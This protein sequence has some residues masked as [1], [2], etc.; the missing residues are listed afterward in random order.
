MR[1]EWSGVSTA[2]STT[3]SP[4]SIFLKKSS[5]HA[6]KSSAATARSTSRAAHQDRLIPWHKGA[7]RVISAAPRPARRQDQRILRLLLISSVGELTEDS[8]ICTTI[9]NQGAYLFL[10]REAL[11]NGV[12]GDGVGLQHTIGATPN[13]TKSFT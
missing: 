13:R 11:R 10:C 2:P 7:R 6:A 5:P 9:W 12:E 3:L 4:R 1:L 8:M